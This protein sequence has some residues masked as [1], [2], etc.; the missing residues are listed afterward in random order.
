MV[1]KFQMSAIPK[2][3]PTHDS[4]RL[5]WDF[6]SDTRFNSGNL[7]W[8]PS[9]PR[10][11]FFISP[12][13][14]Y[15]TLQFKTLPVTHWGSEHMFTYIYSSIAG[16]VEKITT[17]YMSLSFL[18]LDPPLLSHPNFLHMLLML[19]PLDKVTILTIP[20]FIPYSLNTI[21]SCL[22]SGPLYL[23]LI[24]VYFTGLVWD[25]I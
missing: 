2:D 10:C 20:K 18:I 15:T 23:V 17:M 1:V 13:V 21:K 14:S 6:I 11:I 22:L 7:T 19:L 3:G 5:P 8:S 16:S 25:T 9:E 24:R 4:F 12:L